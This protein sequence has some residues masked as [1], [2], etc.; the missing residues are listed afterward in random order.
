MQQADATAF[1]A[2]AYDRG[3]E[4][5]E[6]IVQLGDRIAAAVR[7]IEQRQDLLDRWEELPAPDLVMPDDEEAVSELEQW[8]SDAERLIQ[9]VVYRQKSAQQQGAPELIEHLD[10]A[11]G[12]EESWRY[13]W[14][15]GWN[16][17]KQRAKMLKPKTENP[18]RKYIIGGALAAGVAYVGYQWMKE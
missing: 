11:P 14:I 17:P 15:E 18:Y 6:Y 5:H 10:E 8:I 3:Q 2:Q 13:P 1:Y 12:Y 16:D 9:Y 7:R 4:L